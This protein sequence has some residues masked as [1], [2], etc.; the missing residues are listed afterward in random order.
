[1]KNVCLTILPAILLT[2]L[3]AKPI[4]AQ[5]GNI[6]FGD[7]RVE[8]GT[9]REAKGTNLRPISVEIILYNLSGYILARA[10]VGNNGRYRFIDLLDGDYDLVVSMENSE[11]SRI[12]VQLRSPVVKT[13]F[14]Q[15]ITLEW[16]SI[17]ERSAKPASVSVEDYY[18]RSSINQKRFESAR[19]AI[20]NKKYDEAES[21]LKQLLSEDANDFQ[22]RTE[23]GTVYLFQQDFVKAE[24]AYSEALTV[25][26]KFFLAL[27]NLG[28][29][30]L[31]QSNFEGAISVLSEAVVTKPT[32]AEA[33]YYLGEAY[34]QIKKGSKAVTYLYEALKLD[35][36][37]K[38][39][40]HLRL[41]V[42]YNGAGMKD[43]AA[44]EYEQFLKKKPDY[45]DHK[46]LEQYI[47]ANKS[48]AS[49]KQ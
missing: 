23:L 24:Q 20:N 13:D 18:K 46:K 9:G 27:I 34:L 36:I 49:V 4:Q 32:S 7:V 1:V 45:P 11:V 8:E 41:A 40:A 35:P 16:R 29:L 19:V 10:T 17:D 44:A 33:N 43:K 2:C 37:G 25:R 5:G 14:R 42:L 12:R 48:K 3:L 30:R 39:E 15:D 47:G 38:A 6:L 21:L 28:R 26:P 31:M 22:A